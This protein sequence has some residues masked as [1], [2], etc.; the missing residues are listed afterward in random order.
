MYPV[1]AVRFHIWWS[2]TEAAVLSQPVR[3]TEPNMKV[4]LSAPRQRLI[5]PRIIYP[6]MG[7]GLIIITSVVVT[8]NLLG[9][10]K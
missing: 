2:E 8:P 9:T 5:Y 10:L 4:K 6:S 3:L 1:Y 7:V